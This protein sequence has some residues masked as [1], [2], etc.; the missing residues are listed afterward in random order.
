MAPYF[1]NPTDQ[2]MRI[3]S[4]LCYMS[5]GI[6]GLLYI[7]LNGRNNES[8]FFRFHFIQAILLGIFTMLISFLAPPRPE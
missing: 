7:L 5:S 6:I 3:M 4:A 8:T 2:R 1:N